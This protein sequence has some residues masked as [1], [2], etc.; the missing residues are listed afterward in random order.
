M[1]ASLLLLVSPL[2]LEGCLSSQCDVIAREK[3][4]NLHIFVMDVPKMHRKL[5]KIK[6]LLNW[7]FEKGNTS[8]F[9][10]FCEA[11]GSPIDFGSFFIT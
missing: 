9:E 10:S 3:N 2:R 6:R 11:A 7:V 4:S 5:N 8:Y 1:N